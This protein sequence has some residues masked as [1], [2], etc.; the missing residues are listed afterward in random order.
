MKSLFKNGHVTD[1]ALRVLFDGLLDDDQSLDIAQHVASCGA[2]AGRMAALAEQS[3]AE[4]PRGMTELVL[5]SIERD[6]ERRQRE[7]R[8][9]ALRVAACV[10]VIVGLLV[11]GIFYPGGYKPSTP[12][13]PDKIDVEAP[14]PVTVKTPDE[15]S[16]I[17][18]DI[19]KFLKDLPNLITTSEEDEN[20][21][22]KK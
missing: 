5:E 16:S 3:A 22:T 13:P 14:V 2:C 6:R 9:F 7:F 17:I 15:E 21:K 19:G 8:R 12:A 18:N 1:S 20:D 4:P 10:A 11:T